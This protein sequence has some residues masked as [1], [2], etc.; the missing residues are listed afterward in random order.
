[1]KTFERRQRTSCPLFPPHTRRVHYKLQILQFQVLTTS[2]QLALSAN[3]FGQSHSIALNSHEVLV[4]YITRNLP[5][6]VPDIRDETISAFND[7][8]AAANSEDSSS[9]EF[10]L[11]LSTWQQ[12]V[13][14]IRD[15]FYSGWME[16]DALELVSRIITR[17]NN[18]TLVGHPF[19]MCIR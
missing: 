13:F 18:R 17:V 16:F 2:L 11:S 5:F 12:L 10:S 6:I 1:M 8:M 3:Y 15:S 19:C 4:A 7:A 9:M 14:L